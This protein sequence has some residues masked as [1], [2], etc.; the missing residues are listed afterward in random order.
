MIDWDKY[1]VAESMET[2]AMWPEKGKR[3]SVGDG[4]EGRYVAKKENIG[5][6]K[7]NIYV[8]E[9]NGE[10]VGVW[11]STVLDSKFEQVAIGKMVAIEYT[12]ERES[13]KGN[14]QYSDFKFGFGVD[15]P[16]DEA[17]LDF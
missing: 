17:K 6:F 8:L 14:G 3:L 9:V 2:D 5:K 12:G 4:I 1:Q 11:G 15:F 13:K 7:S 16:K 10:R